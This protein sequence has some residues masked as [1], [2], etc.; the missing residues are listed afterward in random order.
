M[1]GHQRRLAA[2]FDA[3][4]L[5]RR[6]G[7][8]G[9]QLLTLNYHR[10]AEPEDCDFD[11]DLISATPGGFASQLDFLA[12]NADVVGLAD[13]PDVIAARRRGRFVL[14]TFDDGYA[15]NAA[16]AAPLLKD[17]GLPATFFLTS[18]FLDDRRPA[19]WDEIAWMVRRSEAG[20]VEL[21]AYGLSVDTADRAAAMKAVIEHYKTLP[22]G[23]TA[24]YLDAVADACGTGRCPAE[25]A[26][27]LWMTWDDARRL[28]AGGFTVGG[29]TV[30]HP[31]LSRLPA[32]EQAREVADNRRRI[33]AELGVEPTAFS[34]PVGQ[35][36]S[37]TTQTKRA[38]AAAGYETAFSFYGGLCRRGHVDLLNIPRVAVESRHCGRA[39]RSLVS[40]PQVFGGL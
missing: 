3:A 17:R 34:Y 7:G 29:H 31:V 20:R 27:A 39:F 4:G 21:P 19:W 24:A 14:I 22:P 32:G 26:D 5:N 36:D 2:L 28:V 12:R 35:P 16:V 30:S 25:V 23:E 6:R 18:G 10:V 40:W 38:V 15:D 13:V 33:V 1:P 9:A 8:R 37:F 11:R